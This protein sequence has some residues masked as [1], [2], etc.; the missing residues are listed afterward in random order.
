MCTINLNGIGHLLVNDRK[1][2]KNKI[3]KIL[4]GT[5]VKLRK[6]FVCGSYKS[7]LTKNDRMLQI[8]CEV[9]KSLST[10]N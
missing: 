10:V 1:S 9:C 6:C 7:F 5:L 4:I 2:D 8:N 3:E